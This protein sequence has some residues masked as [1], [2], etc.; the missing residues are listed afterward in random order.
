M[1]NLKYRDCLKIKKNSK[2]KKSELLLIWNG[3]TT[4][5]RNVF[6][7]YGYDRTSPRIKFNYYLDYNMWNII[8]NKI[9]ANLCLQYDG[10]TQTW[11]PYAFLFDSMQDKMLYI[12]KH[13]ERL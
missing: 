2:L 8:L 5:W 4:T 3:N 7:D 1:E 12:L 11:K 9:H 10:W 13:P 6:Q